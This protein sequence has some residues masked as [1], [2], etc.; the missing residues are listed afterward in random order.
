MSKL[1]IVT[2]PNDILS[3]KCQNITKLYPNISSVIK[4]MFE[5]LENS[6][7]GVGLAANQVGLNINLFIVNFPVVVNKRVIKRIK[8][9]FINSDI[10]DL[11]GEDV[12]IEEGC[13]SLPGFKKHILRKEKVKIKYLDE[14]FNEREEIYYGMISR[15][16]QHEY[17]HILGKLINQK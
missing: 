10:L 6:E 3:N 7:N 4:D 9:T 13:L 16:I 12:V 8:K 5:T 2:Y 14:N 11:F 15:I 17:D 1:N